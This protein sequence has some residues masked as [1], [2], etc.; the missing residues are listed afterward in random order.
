MVVKNSNPVFRQKCFDQGQK[1]SNLLTSFCFI[2]LKTTLDLN[3]PVLHKPIIPF[4][5]YSELDIPSFLVFFVT[6][7][8]KKYL[9][10]LESNFIYHF[11]R[12]LFRFGNPTASVPSELFDLQLNAVRFCLDL[13][14]KRKKKIWHTMK[15]I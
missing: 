15:V 1:I 3:V 8:C 2:F 4:Y 7:I 5:I 12:F 13:F 11:K 9:Y 14:W 6:I 10:S